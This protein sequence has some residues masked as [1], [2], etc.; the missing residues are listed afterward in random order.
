MIL[1]VQK[2]RG[3]GVQEKVQE[4]SNIIKFILAIRGKTVSAYEIRLGS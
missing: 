2:E 1:L 3:K 4:N